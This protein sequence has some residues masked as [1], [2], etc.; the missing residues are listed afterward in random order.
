MI[1]E[2]FVC[3]YDL[4]C[5]FYSVESRLHE[6]FSLSLVGEEDSR[7]DICPSNTA[8]SVCN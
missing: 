3:Y 5:C 8:L 7:I 2:S 1:S 4:A 6:S